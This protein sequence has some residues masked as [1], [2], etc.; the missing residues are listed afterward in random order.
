MSDFG[1]IDTD[2]VFTPGDEEVDWTRVEQV[3]GQ[4]EFINSI[5][6]PDERLEEAKGW[7]AELNG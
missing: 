2:D 3:A 4:I 7:A 1:D 5:E 6:D